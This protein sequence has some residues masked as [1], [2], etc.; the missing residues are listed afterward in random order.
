MIARDLAN[1]CHLQV[2]PPFE[3]HLP[4]IILL[5]APGLNAKALIGT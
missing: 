2:P 5:L 3:C 4:R 1:V